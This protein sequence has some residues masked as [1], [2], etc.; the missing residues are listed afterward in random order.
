MDW[1]QFKELS[2]LAMLIYIYIHNLHLE[3]KICDLHLQH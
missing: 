1:M 2:S 3:G